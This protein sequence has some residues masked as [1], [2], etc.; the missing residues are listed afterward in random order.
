MLAVRVGTRPGRDRA[1]AE[2]ESRA[3]GVWL[4][5]LAAACLWLLLG[6]AHA[7]PAGVPPVT[8]FAPD[9]AVYPQT[10]DL[11]Q[12]P[13][14]TVYIAA[15]DGVLIFDGARWSL[16]RLPN[17]DMARSVASDGKGRIYVGGYDL[18]GYVE[19]DAGG[20]ARF[21]DLRPLYQEALHGEHF[22]DVWDVLV[23]PQG[24]FFMALSQLF[25]YQPA[26]GQVRLWRNPG[27]YGCLFEYQGGVAAQF[28]GEGLRRLQGQEW[29]PLPGS[30]PL[31]DL[32]Y[33]FLPLPDGG[34]LSLARDGRWREYRDGAVSDYP[35]P[36]AAPASSFIT[37][38][39][40]L[41]DGSL[42]LAGEDGRLYLF[43]PASRALRSFRVEGSALNSVIVARDGGLLSLSNLA[44][45]HVGWPT[46]WTA[47]RSDDGGLGGLLHGI[48]R[49]DGHWLALS[50]SGVYQ[51]D[52]A[53]DA[54][55]HFRR[56]DWT[57]FEAWDLLP[58][59]GDEALLA[60]SYDLKLVRNGRAT[61][62]PG[63]RVAPILL[64]RSK[65]DPDLVYVG[66][67]T[68]L[69]VLH[70]EGGR[71]LL[72]L[73]A[74]DLP[75]GRISS[76]VELGRGELL[77][78]SD[79]DGVY[80]LQLAADLSRIAAQRAYGE[81]AGIAYGQPAAATVMAVGQDALAA[82]AAGLYRWS[83]GRFERTALDGLEPL[84]QKDEMLTVAAAP[85]G[86]QWA[87]SYSRIYHR[88]RGG[89]WQREPLDGILRGS[90]ENLAFDGQDTA[91]F[92][93]DSEMLRHDG[94]VSGAG[95]AP[96]LQL[97]SVERLDPQDQ[98]Q[99]L[100][101]HPERTPVFRQEGLALRFHLA[102]P[103][104]RSAGEARYQVQL[105]GF[106]EYPAAWS[107]SRNYTY[108]KLSPGNYRF[109][110]R[111]RD[112]LGRISETPPYRFIVLPPWYA[113]RLAQ[114][115]GL[116]LLIAAVAA[117]GTVVARRRTWRL[118]AEK[119][120]LENLV[121]LRTRELESANRRLDKLANLDGLTEIPNRRRLND[122]L[123]EVWGHCSE[124][125]RPVSVLVIDVDHFKRYNDSYGHLAGD[126]VLKKLTQQ[127]TA[128][129]RRAEDLVA[130]FGGDEFVA[131]LPGAALPV[132]REV[133]EIMRA[134]VEDG[135]LG[136][137]ISVGYSSRL[138]QPNESVWALVH[139]V[140]GALYE[141]KRGGRNRVAPFDAS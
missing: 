4:G 25:E 28:R 18:F 54:P 91:L 108:R 70:R 51:A 46:A 14:G 30:A 110:A 23:A 1:R 125:G 37:G 126:E 44:L 77:A 119:V 75:A 35:M 24:V 88:P 120:Q 90:I 106:S 74:A 13:Y 134:R 19:R 130:R 105:E 27:Q 99:P 83:G 118:A 58:L 94:G 92:A 95:G 21:H 116:L 137:T 45:L 60:E 86:G 52:D 136:V 82:T 138:P 63:A 107:A 3:G 129:L 20:E 123:S 59:D 12:D 39:R 17:G 98:P 5:R 79:R 81:D 69:A 101:L 53:A 50:D 139:E 71:W 8:R 38:G 124:L 73:N 47:I 72:K 115:L 67:D 49:W 56:L 131:V 140:D 93:A 113:S 61:A 141:A 34:L 100:P 84:R 114:A 112:S 10:F 96:Q 128:C 16:L 132:A 127:L 2:R 32:V 122:Y 85:D 62:L 42:A 9:I 55:A 135:G 80:R 78:G 66:T 41:A 22:A 76:L 117:V 64:R 109:V 104:Y 11:A 29:Q 7:A 40:A 68:G 31:S 121:R 97:G 102:L 89:A 48:A 36:A 57:D 26:D 87:Y 103:D 43:D 133:A 111:A 33:H 6:A 65:F 15:N